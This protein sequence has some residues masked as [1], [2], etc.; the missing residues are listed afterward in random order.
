MAPS[1][2][3]PCSSDGSELGVDFSSGA[4]WDTSNDLIKDFQESQT[5]LLS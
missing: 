5:L 4:A 1:A 2:L 3:T